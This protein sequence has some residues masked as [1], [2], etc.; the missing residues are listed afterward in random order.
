MD[1]LSPL[2]G[3]ELHVHMLG[4][5]YAEDL[6]EMGKDIYQDID[7][8]EFNFIENYKEAYGV[9]PEPVARFQDALTNGTVGFERFKRFYVYGDEEEQGDFK[10]WEAKYCFF[11]CIWSHWREMDRTRD[12]IRHI[13]ERHH[14]EGFDYVEYRCRSSKEGFMYWH[15]LCAEEFQDAS[16]EGLTARYILGLKRSEPMEDYLMLHHLLDEHPEYI[17]V[18]VGLDFAG[19][20]EGVPPKLVRSF[21][22]RVEQDNRQNPER[23]LDIVYHVGESYF[24][25]SLESAIRW[26]HEV[27]EMGAK[28]IAHAIALGLDPA[29]AI[30]RRPY[31]HE[32][33]LVSERLD[34]VVYDLQHAE[35]LS[36]YGIEVNERRLIAEKEALQKMSPDEQIE[37]P[38]DERRLEEVRRR[39][40]FVLDYLTEL[41]TVIECCP[42][43]N[44]RIGGVPDAAYH[45]I[46]RFM[47]SQVNLVICSDD[48][49]NFDSPLAAEVDWV[50]ANTGMS[51]EAVL[52]R[53]GGPRRFALGQSRPHK[54]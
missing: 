45:P 51:E 15:T 13:L 50:L 43:S 23:A 52:K 2:K 47:D 49:G 5:F 20:E 14:A 29:V 17:P 38:Y 31:A 48:P 28:R 7:W 1:N 22:K 32:Q 27:A 18:F 21:F 37:R 16:L 33:E 9:H 24:D 41:G 35:T 25:K 46:H 10:K 53:L 26:C 8:N 4:T 3:C 34:Q 6:L 40:Q 12:L 44:L 11:L 19:A 54:L 39:Q 42:T 36:K 30:E